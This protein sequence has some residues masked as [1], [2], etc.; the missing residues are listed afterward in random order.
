MILFFFLVIGRRKLKE[1]YLY[2]FWVVIKV[3]VEHDD[4]CEKKSIDLAFCVL[5]THLL[6]FMT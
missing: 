5:F 3:F 2:P 4:F 6:G 1:I